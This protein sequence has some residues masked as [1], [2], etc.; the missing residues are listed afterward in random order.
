MGGWRQQYDYFAGPR[1]PSAVGYAQLLTSDRHR[2]DALVAYALNRTFGRLRRLGTKAQTEAELRRL[3]VARYLETV[4]T[5]SGA[6]TPGQASTTEGPAGLATRAEDPTDHAVWAPATRESRE[7]HAGPK[8]PQ[9][10]ADQVHAALA[11]LSPQVRAMVVLRH[12]DGLEP[13]MIAAQLD[14]E[15]G[16][17]VKELRASNSV[18]GFQLG[19]AAPEEPDPIATVMGYGTYEIMVTA[20]KESRSNE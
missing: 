2:A 10:E 4:D 16:R 15:H 20:P 11:M 18:L 7:A 3:M 9:D 13:A 12:V 8:N 14:V 1:Y 5:E 17:V 6:D 19:V